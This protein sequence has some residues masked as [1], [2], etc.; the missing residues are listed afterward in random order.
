MMRTRWLAACLALA[1]GPIAA[2][3]ETASATGGTLVLD[4]NAYWRYY[5]RFGVDRLDAKVLK[6]EADQLL[7]RRNL[8]RL[9]KTVR[10]WS[11]PPYAEKATDFSK[12]DWRDHAPFF[13]TQVANCGCNDERISLNARSDP[14][15]A[16]WMKPDSPA[17]RWQ[18]QRLPLLVGDIPSRGIG[19]GVGEMKQPLVRGGYFRTRFDVPDP[20]T[21]GTYTLHLTFRGGVR[22][23]VNGRELTRSHLPDGPIGPDALA[24]SYPKAAYLCLEGEASSRYVERKARRVGSGFVPY[25]PDLPGDI[26]AAFR[27]HRGKPVE[28]YRGLVNRACWRRVKRLRDRTVGPIEVPRRLLRAGGNLLAVEVRPAPLHP[29]VAAAPRMAWGRSYWMGRTSPGPTPACWAWS[30]A[31]TTPRP[32][33]RWSGRRG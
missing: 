9:A 10:R 4:E 17:R 20:G 22:V 2:G 24:E 6:D 5:V 32:R 3:G 7:G 23:F 12:V 28:Y 1:A 21:A 11:A 31:A 33:R 8:G 27:P 14:P 25:C 29:I 30:C 16:D 19:H 26:E 13:V 18:R 15:P